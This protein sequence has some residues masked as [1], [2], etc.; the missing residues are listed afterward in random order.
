MTVLN[1]QPYY[2]HSV[3]NI[4]I[5]FATLFNDISLVRRDNGDVEVSR[6]KIPL[7]YA[8]QNS[9]YKRIKSK[10]S[11]FDKDG[12][13]INI[14]SILPAMSFNMTSMSY[15][16]ARKTN[17]MNNI[18]VKL[19]GDNDTSKIRGT[20]PA[21][22]DFDFTLNAYTKNIEDGLQI[23]EQIAP[24]FQPSI[25]IKIKMAMLMA[26]ADMVIGAGGSATWERC[27]VWG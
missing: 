26:A 2:N 17:T 8:D 25:A 13:G 3:R 23:V 10:V 5:A 15:S 21:P 1:N 16:P 19:P 22:Y 14:G 11:D 9:W 4:N 6:H 18:A 27:C 12:A 7:V 20:A 24:F